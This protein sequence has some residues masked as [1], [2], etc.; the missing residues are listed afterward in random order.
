M[1]ENKLNFNRNED[2]TLIE[3]VDGKLAK[4]LNDIYSKIKMNL[5]FCYEQ[6]V[7]GNLSKG[8]LNIHISLTESY[9]LNFLKA[10]GYDGILEAEHNERFV[11]IRALHEQNRLLR[12]QLG[13]KVTNED[14]RERVKNMTKS[15]KDWWRMYGFGHVSEIVFTD[16]S[17]KVKL[18]GM[19]FESTKIK[20]LKDLG[21]EMSGDGEKFVCA[22]DNNIEILTK[23]LTN[24]YPSAS[25]WEMIISPSNKNR[26]IKDIEVFINNFDDIK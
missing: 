4:N 25:I 23:L 19:I 17:M 15:V 13:Q 1:I 20:Y 6:L 8:M 3:D 2:P 9:V 16:Y 7:A 11:E 21:F 12:E 18:S 26:E 5:G 24:K 10:V 22:N 14:F